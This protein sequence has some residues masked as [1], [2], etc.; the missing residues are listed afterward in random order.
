MKSNCYNLRNRSTRNLTGLF[1]AVGLVVGGCS[2]QQ[3]PAPAAQ[4]NKEGAPAA[5]RAAK[6]TDAPS[7]MAS[8]RGDWPAW[9]GPT[10][11]RNMYSPEHGLPDR[12]EPGKNKPGS[13]EI[14]LK[15]AK[16]L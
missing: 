1:A 9:G 10:T 2:K 4:A 16:N 12:F 6:P 11:A 5:A 13:E 3:E 15:T 7:N 8:V 14:D